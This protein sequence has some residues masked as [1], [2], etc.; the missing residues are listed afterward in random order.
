MVTVQDIE[1]RNND[2]VYTAGATRATVTVSASRTTI[3]TQQTEDLDVPMLNNLYIVGGNSN[4]ILQYN[5]DSQKYKEFLLKLKDY[6]ILE[7]RNQG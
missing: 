7:R 2:G 6:G 3:V 5:I 4:S 1:F